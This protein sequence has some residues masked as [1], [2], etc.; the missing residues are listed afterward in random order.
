MSRGIRDRKYWWDNQITF[1]KTTFLFF[2]FQFRSP[3]LTFVDNP[4]R[5]ILMMDCW[6]VA[7]Q[8]RP[9]F[10]ELS[11]HLSK[12]FSDEKVGLI[13]KISFCQCWC[14]V[15][16]N[17]LDWSKICPKLWSLNRAV[18]VITCVWCCEKT[19][20]ALNSYWTSGQHLA[21]VPTLVNQCKDLYT[22]HCLIAQSKFWWHW[23]VIF[24]VFLSFLESI[25][26]LL[27]SLPK[28]NL[29]LLSLSFPRNT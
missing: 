9:T 23:S 25:L 2:F 29:R 8:R 16:K 12:M 10:V 18:R 28:P 4:S 14:C 20:R 15:I 7:P 19:R 27:S 3:N 13:Q 21:S 1:V 26:H 17:Y 5:Y 6:Q 11:Q 22:V 24:F